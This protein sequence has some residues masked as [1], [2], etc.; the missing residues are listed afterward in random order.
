MKKLK[1]VNKIKNPG[2]AKLPKE[3]RN[4]MGYMKEGGKAETKKRL[5]AAIRA[6]ISGGAAKSVRAGSSNA[7]LEGRP[8][9]RARKM[10]IENSKKNNLNLLKR[11]GPT[12]REKAIKELSKMDRKPMMKKG[13]KLSQA[14]KNFKQKRQAKKD[15][16]Y[17]AEFG[18][19]FDKKGNKT[20]SYFIHKERDKSIRKGKIKGAVAG[21]LTAAALNKLG[22]NKGKTGQKLGSAALLT[23]KGAV[24]GALTSKPF[25]V[26]KAREEYKKY[27]KSKKKMAEGGKL[28]KVGIK[29]RK[30]ASKN[31]AKLK[32]KKREKMK[33]LDKNIKGDIAKPTMM[34]GG[35]VQAPS[36]IGDAVATYQGSGNYK[37][38]E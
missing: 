31:L 9:S 25:S 7:M 13:G 24:I 30:D 3:V 21:A 26:K 38:G 17:L 6:G 29:T 35:Q 14:V 32:F 10:I 33:V 37:A 11:K 18:P 20:L 12:A 16:T 36:Q 28:Y 2:L 22:G 15:S 4:K 1:T 34:E 23:G 8:M 19:K 27:L 5:E